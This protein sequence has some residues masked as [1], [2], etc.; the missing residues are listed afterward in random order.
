MRNNA[1]LQRTT[2]LNF[3]SADELKLVVS[4]SVFSG[5]SKSNYRLSPVRD[6]FREDPQAGV[7]VKQGSITP[8]NKFKLL[9]Y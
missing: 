1:Q 8:D 7:R 6:I 2:N 5:D 9:N 4:Y 3:C